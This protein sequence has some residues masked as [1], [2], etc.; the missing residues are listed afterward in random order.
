[1][2]GL[3]SM[4]VF[5]LHLEATEVVLMARVLGTV[6]DATAVRKHFSAF[7]DTV[8]HTSRPTVVKRNRDLFTAIS[9]RMQEELLQ[10]YRLT[11]RCHREDDDTI[12]GTLMEIDLAANAA[13]AAELKM[14]IAHDLVEY[15]LEYWENFDLYFHSPNRRAHLPHVLRVLL[16]P[17]VDRVAALIDA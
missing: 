7:V 14:V 3:Y 12:S 10:P 16:Q 1:M 13:N 11:L 9:V 17:D 2:Y 8:V 6:R 4:Y 5:L 15:A